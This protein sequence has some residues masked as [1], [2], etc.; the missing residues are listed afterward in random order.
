MCWERPRPLRHLFYWKSFTNDRVFRLM[1]PVPR[2]CKACRRPT[3]N[4][5]QYCDQHQS[6]FKPPQRR[7]DEHRGSPSKRGYDATWRRF[8]QVFLSMHPLCE[9]CESEGRITPALEVHHVVPLSDGGPRL[10]PDNC[11][12][13]CRSCHSK[14]T[15]ES[16]K[17]S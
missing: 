12:A 5:N 3:T 10:D 13:L 1:K 17:M 4:A 14:I 9:V 8:R 16:R 7:Y 2:P 11:R 6:E 15:S